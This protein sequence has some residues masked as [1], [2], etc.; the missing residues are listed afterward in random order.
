M[1]QLKNPSGNI[2]EVDDARVE[3]LVKKGFKLIDEN[4]NE[5]QK[6]VVGAEALQ[7]QLEKANAEIADLKAQLAKAAAEVNAAQDSVKAAK[8]ET[9]EA[10]KALEAAQVQAANANAPVTGSA[11]PETAQE[12]VPGDTPG[13]PK[14]K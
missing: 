5:V 12:P 4:G 8:A 7:A 11:H 10:R 13:T 14:K 1:P 2:I 9:A 6:P 3:A